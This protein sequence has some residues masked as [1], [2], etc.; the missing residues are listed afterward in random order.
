M[1]PVKICL[2]RTKFCKLVD[3]KVIDLQ[4]IDILQKTPGLSEIRCIGVSIVAVAGGWLGPFHKCTELWH[5]MA[6]AN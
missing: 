4:T 5:V 3:R 2:A 1:G 6:P